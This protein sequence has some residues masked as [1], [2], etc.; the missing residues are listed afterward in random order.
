M[1]QHEPGPCPAPDFEPN[2]APEPT[3][4][5]DFQAMLDRRG[6]SLILQ[7]DEPEIDKLEPP[8]PCPQCGEHRGWRRVRSRDIGV[9]STLEA[10]CRA[11]MLCADIPEAFRWASFDSADLSKRVRRQGAI[12]E[13]REATSKRRVILVGPAGAGKTSLLVAMFRARGM[14]KRERNAFQLAWRLGVARQQH[15][16]GKG[17]PPMVR[18]SLEAPILCLDD[19]GAEKQTQTNAVPDVIFER[20]AQ[21]QPFWCTTALTRKEV[22]ERYGDGI[23][24]RLGES[25]RIIDCTLSGDAG[26]WG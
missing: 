12:I 17:E 20:H 8:G 2:P 14:A 7:P 5:T 26:G 9:S 6:Q 16:L 10:H 15:E 3:S 13:A 24:R 11:C 23:G 25:A 21:G 18:R 1:R 4:P 19:L 22:H